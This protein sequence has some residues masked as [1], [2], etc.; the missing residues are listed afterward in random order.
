MFT[1]PVVNRHA[2]PTHRLFGFA[3]AGKGQ[4]FAHLR[5]THQ[6][7]CP[8]AAFDG[9]RVGDIVAKPVQS[10]L[11]SLFATVRIPDFDRLQTIATLVFDDLD[12]SR[13]P[14]DAETGLGMRSACALSGWVVSIAK[15]L[16]EQGAIS[17]QTIGEQGHL[18]TIVQSRRAILEQAANQD[19]VSRSLDVGQN[20]LTLGVHQFRF[21]GWLLLIAG[22]AMSFIRL[23]FGN[24]P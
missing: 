8:V 12:M 17:R 21:P 24:G 20:E 10:L 15:Y 18:M 1:T 19:L 6:A 3:F 13:R 7:G 14:W 23:Q 9:R 4:G 16:R 5:R 11:N 2:P 22:K